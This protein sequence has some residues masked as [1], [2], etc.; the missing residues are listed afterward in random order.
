M[1]DNQSVKDTPKNFAKMIAIQM[2]KSKK[3]Q[4]KNQLS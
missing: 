1:A 4:N 2:K 3:S